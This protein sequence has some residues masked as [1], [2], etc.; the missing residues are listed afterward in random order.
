MGIRVRVNLDN[1]DRYIDRSIERGKFIL[2]NQ[3]QAD[4]NIYVPRLSGDLRRYSQVSNNNENVIWSQP[5]ARIQYYGQ[6]RN[7][8]TPGTGPRWD[9][10]AK[11][12]HLLSWIR[13]TGGAFN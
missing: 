13:A 4:S 6:F 10:I 2:A 7:Y 5:Y 12:N 3:V 1:V 9:E 8:T 11:R